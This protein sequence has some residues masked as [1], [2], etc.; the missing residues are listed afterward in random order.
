MIAYFAG[1]ALTGPTDSEHTGP[2]DFPWDTQLEVIPIIRSAYARIAARGNQSGV[3]GFG[4]LRRYGSLLDAMEARALFVPGLP[5]TGQLELIQYAG[6]HTLVIF[7]QAGR[8][9]TAAPVLHGRAVE[10]RFSFAVGRLLWTR[11]PGNQGDYWDTLE[12]LRDEAGE[13]VLDEND[14]AIQTL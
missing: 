11:I 4:C 9:P 10:F 1:Q 2:V 6:G 8:A 13:L 12:L 14:F 5:R 7:G 3:V